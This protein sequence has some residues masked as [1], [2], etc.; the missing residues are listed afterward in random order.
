[1]VSKHCIS[2][3]KQVLHKNLKELFLYTTFVYSQFLYKLN[4]QWLSQVDVFTEE[5][6]Q[7]LLYNVASF[8]LQI[9]ECEILVNLLHL[10]GIKCKV[11]DDFIVYL[12]S[13][14]HSAIKEQDLILADCVHDPVIVNHVLYVYEALIWIILLLL[15]LKPAL[16]L[17]I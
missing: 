17:L 5:E 2:W 8:N 7:C 10:E 11:F 16:I 12:S 1:M 6:I 3:V 4:L 15:L 14:L 13:H 9:Q